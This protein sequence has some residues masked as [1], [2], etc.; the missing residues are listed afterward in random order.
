M[1]K[2]IDFNHTGSFKLNRIE[3]LISKLEKKFSQYI[4]F[5]KL[6]CTVE[7]K[8]FTRVSQVNYSDS[9][10]KV[11]LPHKYSNKTMQVKVIF[12]LRKNLSYEFI[13]EIAEKL[14]LWLQ[15]NA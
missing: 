3:K 12:G 2:R 1:I 14:N 4:S 15:C 5:V 9:L 7:G 10:I 6:R 8:N 13:K 11:L